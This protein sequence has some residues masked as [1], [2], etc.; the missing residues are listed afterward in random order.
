MT[1]LK[2][3]HLIWFWQINFPVDLW[4]WIFISSMLQMLMWSNS[5]SQH[6][7]I[8]VVQCF[9]LRSSISSGVSRLRSYQYK[10]QSIHHIS[11]FVSGVWRSFKSNVLF[12]VDKIFR[13]RMN[14]EFLISSA[15]EKISAG[16]N[17]AMMI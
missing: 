11:N 2:A 16:C 6:L 10:N 1:F 12:I 3:Y 14:I 8:P 17:V 9:I 4:C 7:I 15:N 5:S 13:A